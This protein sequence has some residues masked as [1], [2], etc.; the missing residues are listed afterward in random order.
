[1]G[2]AIGVAFLAGLTAWELYRNR[3][4]FGLAGNERQKL[5]FAIASGL[6][7]LVAALAWRL[8]NKPANAD[9]LIATDS[10]MKK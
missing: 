4:Y 2:T 9:F 1:M 6:F 5:A 3:A 8:M 7:V 10:E